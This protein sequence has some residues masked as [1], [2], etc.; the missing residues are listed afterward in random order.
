MKKPQSP[1]DLAPSTGPVGRES[2]KFML[3]FPDG[4]RDRIAESAK[5]NGRS[6][7]AEIVSR[8]D[9]SLNSS[10]DIVSQKLLR[11]I[12]LYEEKHGI[13]FG[14]AIER[15]LY[16]GLQPDAPSVVV[17][18]VD[19]ALEISKLASFLDLIVKKT[20]K[21]SVVAVEPPEGGTRQP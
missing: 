6:M 14:E 19:S 4:M 1:P 13:N 18:H 8:L 12:R 3:R 17:L 9:V 5:K 2:D 21:G 20:P 10:A 7:N 11:E 16:A 15:L